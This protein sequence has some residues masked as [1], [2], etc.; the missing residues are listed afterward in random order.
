MYK[1]CKFP[2]NDQCPKR[3]LTALNYLAIHHQTLH[4][5]TLTNNKI[6]N[7]LGKQQS[8]SADVAIPIKDCVVVTNIYD[9]EQLTYHLQSKALAQ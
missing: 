5:F 1:F 9:F 6:L 2:S 3:L 4:L 8:N 7:W